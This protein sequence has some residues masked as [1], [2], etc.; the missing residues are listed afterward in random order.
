MILYARVRGRLGRATIKIKCTAVTVAINFCKK[1]DL[2]LL[3][4]DWN[5]CD[6]VFVDLGAYGSLL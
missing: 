6:C 2:E 3:T 5:Y 4:P 1:N